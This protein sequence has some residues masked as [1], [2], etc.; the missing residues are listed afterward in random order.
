MHSD[1]L[2][3]AQPRRPVTTPYRAALHAAAALL[4]MLVIPVDTTRASAQGNPPWGSAAHAYRLS[5]DVTP[6]ADGA[7]LQAVAG[8]DFTTAFLQ[9][10]AAGATLDP[11]SLVV[12]EVDAAGTVIDASV[13]LQFD[14]DPG[15][16]AAS[17]A[18]GE[19]V[20][21]VAGP[22]SAAEDRRYLVY[23]DTPTAGA[24][25]TVVADRVTVDTTVVDEGEPAMSITTPSAT[26]W[27]QTDAGGFSSLV[28]PAG[29]DWIGW[30]TS[31]GAAGQYRGI[32]NLVYPAGWFHPGATGHTTSLDVDGPLRATLTTSSPDGRWTMVWDV[33]PTHAVGTVVEADA[34]YW[35]LYEGTPGGTLEP[36]TDFYALSTGATDTLSG[37]FSA[38]IAAPE[39]V[40][41]GDPV[42][43]R[44][45]F[46]IH[47]DDDGETD[48]YSTLQ[49][50][51]TV[52]GFGRSG[53]SRHLTGNDRTFTVG[54]LDT[55][56]PSAAATTIGGLVVA[57]TTDVGPG[58]S[59]I[60]DETPPVIT[61]P[62][63]AT[64]THDR[65]DVT[66]GTDEYA[67][68]ELSVGLT[69]ALD[70]ATFTTPGAHR[71]HAVAATGLSCDT[72]YHWAVTSTDA[73]GNAV[74]SP[75]QQT[76]TDVC[77]DVSSRVGGEL[78]L[79]EF[80]VVAGAGGGGVVPDV[81]GVGVPLDL[82]VGEGAGVWGVGGLV[83][84][85]GGAGVVASEGGAVKVADAVGVSGAVSVEVW[86][87]PADVTQDGPARI[88]EVGSGPLARNVMV[89]QGAWGSRPDAV[90]AAR[91]RTSS[92][93]GGTP[94]V[95]SAD[96]SAA[97]G[98]SHV[99]VSRDVGGVV[100]V[101]VDGV[102][103]GS[104]SLGGVLS[105][106]DGGFPLVV[107]NSADGSRP[108]AGTVCL[109]AVHDVA[110]SAQEVAAN[111]QAGCPTTPPEPNDPPSAGDDAYT[112]AEDDP[113]VVEAP[114]VLANDSDPD[115]DPLT[116]LLASD[117]GEGTLA[118]QADGSFTYDP[119]PDFF[120]TDTF[121][122]RASDGPAQSPPATVTIT[123]D[124]SPDPPVAVA[125][126]Y[127]TAPD[128]PLS[129]PAPGVL[130]N[131]R[132]PDLEPITAELVT[133]VADGTLALAADGSFDYTPD[134][135]FEGRDQFDYRTTDGTTASAP[136][137]VAIDVAVSSEPPRFLT[138]SLG[139]TRQVIAT[140]VD[141][142]HI[143]VAADVD[144]DGAL[145]VVATDFV[146]DQVLLLRADGAGGYTRTVLDPALDGAYPANVGDVDGDGDVDVVAS[147]Y[148]AD[149]HVW[150][151]NDGT[152][153][154][155]RHVVDASADGA[156][157]IV[158]HDL[159]GDGDNDLLT[160]NQ[161][162]GTVTWYENDGAQGFTLRT[163]DAVANG[164]KRA[165]VGDLDGD[166]DPDVVA[167]SFADDTIAWHENDGTGG[168]T[169][170]VIDTQA[171]GAYF[172]VAGD[173]DGDGQVDVLS[174]SQLDD[175]IAW[176]RNDGTGGWAKQVIDGAAL[177]ARTVEV[178]DV[179]GDGDLDA[180][181]AAVDG[182]ALAWYEND[183][184][185]QFSA[186]PI[187]LT[188]D[189]AYGVVAVDIDV[190][191][192]I[193]ALS[194]GRD[195]NTVSV[196][197]QH[198]TH[199]ANVTP[200][201]TL[202]IGPAVL[203]AA[204]PDTPP[205]GLVFT[206][207]VPPSAGELRRDGVVLAAGE[208]FTQA[209]VDAG[210]LAY[211]HGGGRGQG[212]VFDLRL[213]DLGAGP[214]L[215]ST[216]EVVV[217]DGSALAV[218]LELDEGTGTLATDASGHGN[219]GTLE[220]GAAFDPRTIDGS[221]S[222]VDL[223]G[224]SSRIVLPAVDL[225]VGEGLT[226]GLRFRPDDFGVA[227]A[228]L[229]SQATGTAAADHLVM[230]STV[231]SGG[232]YVLRGRVRIGGVTQT[233]VASGGPMTAGRWHHAAL[234]HDGATIRLFLDGS[235][236][237]STLHPGVVDADPTVPVAV[238]AQPVGPGRH[239]DGLVDDVRLFTRALSPAEVLALAG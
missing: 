169:E 35:F 29:A 85:G 183:G 229:V 106:W 64:A 87:D 121:T 235:E 223:N 165:E 112:V 215:H 84:S 145:D 227:D 10:G 230:L 201:G 44:S 143:A 5:L 92:S 203:A 57:P 192:D 137:T 116:A 185:G 79:Y 171:N 170:H 216:F 202:P 126:D 110:L 182:D 98:L 234:T 175:T 21:E 68:S 119:A 62:P 41:F 34:S 13:A 154:F 167:A 77:P 190:D 108:W 125:D 178:A 208:T 38:D 236:V 232:E 138:G 205:S 228:R 111:H 91:V 187:D 237:G 157:S 164:A 88:V 140:D 90:F 195:D 93:V 104:G 7:T 75:T 144:G 180:M 27:Y 124:P 12:H 86:V 118:L 200:S 226:I 123:V 96:G 139:F 67:T 214:P 177:G 65:L 66:W 129:I 209:D 8:I 53:L 80:G 46:V 184:T 120:G 155:T 151:D 11:A 102:L 133:D 181:A 81:S 28:D 14:P 39:W 4:L 40:Q 15:F 18:V 132:D 233:I 189:G 219:D 19:L 148:D 117:V 168:F 105:N 47:H 158:V 207:E 186:A 17:N 179:D 238:G 83:L 89:G 16:D 131:D 224:S 188:V 42:A 3:A 172:A 134:P 166:G 159:D 213:S 220:G 198:R 49:D 63:N 82:V 78:V 156:H 1:Q 94:T 25:G 50:E 150:Y 55:A 9:A 146:D 194:A 196:H 210:L 52:F 135:G 95:F 161:D 130:A 36:T 73:S 160:T 30:N 222:S 31:S 204:D 43:D 217:D 114:G 99:V 197:L 142:T 239:F 32:P 61:T 74:S 2:A 56:D 152:G 103:A 72:T 206:V 58:Q 22:T 113:L 199:R 24:P 193:D 100:S 59:S 127:R 6:A 149:T 76:T 162:A 136:A 221:P 191:G 225:S 48:S 101:W 115:G 128:T 176:Y 212:D 141:Q 45:L 54:L 109:V 163:I 173:V 71:S 60:A 153:T 147:G 211:V 231:R 23:F 107:G 26:W 33:H 218:H 37:S 20:V 51:M 122:Y 70:L 174:A 69:A 97:V